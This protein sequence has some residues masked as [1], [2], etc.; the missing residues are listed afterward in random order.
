MWKKPCRCSRDRLWTAGAESRLAY[1]LGS[2]SPCQDVQGP[3]PLRFAPS[4]RKQ[5]ALDGIFVSIFFFFPVPAY[6]R[7][8]WV[9]VQT[10][11]FL[12]LLRTSEKTGGLFLLVVQD[13]KLRA[14]HLS[15][16]PKSHSVASKHRMYSHFS[17]ILQRLPPHLREGFDFGFPFLNA[18]VLQFAFL[19]PAPSAT[20]TDGGF[21]LTIALFSSRPPP[22]HLRYAAGF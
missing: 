15:A 22:S 3:G 17:L 12:V 10:Y 20:L 11:N 18:C 16:P 7:F 14:H 9:S 1:R 8:I 19:R 4:L 6:R 5:E 21:C 2:L 13:P